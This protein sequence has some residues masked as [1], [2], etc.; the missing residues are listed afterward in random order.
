MILI[1]PH[2]DFEKIGLATSCDLFS[3]ASSCGTCERLMDGNHRANNAKIAAKLNKVTTV[4]IGTPLLTHL[5]NQ[6]TTRI[7]G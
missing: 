6:A 3:D 1:V 2:A 4:V 7:C 5:V